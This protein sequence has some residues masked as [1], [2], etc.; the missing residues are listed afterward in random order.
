MQKKYFWPIL[1]VLVACDTQTNLGNHELLGTWKAECHDF[2]STTDGSGSSTADELVFTSDSM[3][4]YDKWYSGTGC[5]KPSNTGK[6]VFSL[7]LKSNGGQGEINFQGLTYI[8]IPHTQ[9]VLDYYVSRY[10][11]EFELNKETDLTDVAP[12][13]SEFDM[14]YQIYKIQE[15][16]LYFGA[17][18]GVRDGTSSEKRPVEYALNG[19][20]RQ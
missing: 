3:I 20:S 6:I 5:I 17:S 9:E 7:E 8:V 4:L 13:V 11:Y 15:D 16:V 14:N 18:D 12:Q 1:A 10:D 19:Y 2:Q